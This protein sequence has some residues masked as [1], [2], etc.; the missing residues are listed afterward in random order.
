MFPY[1]ILRNQCYFSSPDV[2]FSAHQ[3]FTKVQVS[4]LDGIFR[5]YKSYYIIK[6]FYFLRCYCFGSIMMFSSIELLKAKE[7]NIMLYNIF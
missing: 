5:E 6:N 7:K 2:L 3:I 4:Q 1:E